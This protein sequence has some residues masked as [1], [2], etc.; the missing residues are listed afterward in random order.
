MYSYKYN[1]MFIRIVMSMCKD[2]MHSYKYI[3]FNVLRYNAMFTRN[4]KD[5]C[6]DACM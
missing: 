6:H 2:K 1:G 3:N 4:N 5:D